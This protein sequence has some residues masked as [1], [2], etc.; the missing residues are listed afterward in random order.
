[1]GLI[2]TNEAKCMDCYRCVRTCPV[3]AISITNISDKKALHV[4]VIDELC[5][6][7][8]RCIHSC[9]QNAKKLSNDDLEQVKQLL[10]KG[11]QMA[12][13]VAPSFRCWCALE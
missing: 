1:M 5:I 7:C 6:K 11:V 2:T 10:G 13:T 3:K 12:C 9:P 8:G 4:Q